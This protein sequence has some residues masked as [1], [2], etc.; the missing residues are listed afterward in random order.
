MMGHPDAG[1][2]WQEF[3][4]ALEMILGRLEACENMIEKIVTGFSGA[5][6][7]QKRRSLMGGL[8]EKH[9]AT[10]EG[11]SGI[12]GELVGK[13]PLEDIVEQIMSLREKGE[14]FDEEAKVS[15]LIQTLLGKFGKWIP[16]PAEV[17]AVVEVEAA[18]EAKPEEEEEAPKKEFR[19][20][21]PRI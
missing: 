3:G 16:K 14:D 11:I 6:S 5:I 4:P 8:K 21:G 12:Y 9:G 13:D 7:T 18:P 17:E 20:E 19:L 2:D 15:E 1:Q 10:L